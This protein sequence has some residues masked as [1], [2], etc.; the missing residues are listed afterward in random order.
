MKSKL[1]FVSGVG[2]TTQIY[3][4]VLQIFASLGANGPKS[5]K[6]RPIARHIVVYTSVLLAMMAGCDS[7]CC[8]DCASCDS[9]ASGLLH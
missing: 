4:L 6:T 7:P 9:I 3:V 1:F 5:T 2:K 8:E